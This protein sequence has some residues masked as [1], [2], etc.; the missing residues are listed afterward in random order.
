MRTPYI[1]ST[2]PLLSLRLLALTA[3]V[4]RLSA[5]QIIFLRLICLFKAPSTSLSILPMPSRLFRKANPIFGHFWSG[6]C[7]SFCAEEDKNNLA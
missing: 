7:F 1:V 3:S 5:L 4:L 6:L 2:V